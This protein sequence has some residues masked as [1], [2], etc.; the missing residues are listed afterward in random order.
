MK[1]IQLFEQ[2]VNEEHTD[3]SDIE[4]ELAK[5]GIKHTS[6]EKKI[7]SMPRDEMLVIYKDGGTTRSDD[8]IYVNKTQYG[9]DIRRVVDYDFEYVETDAKLT[10]REVAKI[11]KKL[12][13][14]LKE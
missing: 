4:K 13:P 7:A 1:H 5:Q 9:I 6:K 10:P 11:V 2:F 12:L 14:A 3:Y 8:F